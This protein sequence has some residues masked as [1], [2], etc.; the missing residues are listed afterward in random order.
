MSGKTLEERIALLQM[1]YSE[2]DYPK[3]I[4]ALADNERKIEDLKIGV[5]EFELL[6]IVVLLGLLFTA[7]THHA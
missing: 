4:T 3:M 7:V 5:L 1:K 6:F 2:K